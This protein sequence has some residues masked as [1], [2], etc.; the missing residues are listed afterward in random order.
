MIDTKTEPN[1]IIESQSSK[2]L[3]D[4][5]REIERLRAK[6]VK[7]EKYTYLGMLVA[8]IFHDQ[9]NVIA[10]ILTGARANLQRIAQ[11]EF[12]IKDFGIWFEDETEEFL[13][14]TQKELIPTI[15]RSLG[16]IEQK[17]LQLADLSDSIEN[18]TS[19]NPSLVS[20]NTNLNEILED[21]I[22]ITIEAFRNKTEK[23]G[24]Q[25][26][27][28]NIATQLDPLI[29]DA[30]AEPMNL[31]RIL[32][33]LLDNAF[34]AVCDKALTAD[35]SYNPT[36][37]VITQRV[38]NCIKIEIEDNGAGMVD[39][40]RAFLTTVTTKPK[41]EGS[42]LGLAIVKRLA[43]EENIKLQAHTGTYG[44]IRVHTGTYGY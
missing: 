28:I 23:A 22:K 8:E 11:I 7:Q 4:K 39:I 42:G 13:G 33:N 6:I 20:S 41:G 32:L 10:S 31:R 30:K 21:C 37:T 29:H 18:Y 38:D 27:E 16:N 17:A 24:K 44:Y 15:K 3:A 14:E 26:S 40:Y 12:A 9:K 2:I 35:K 1:F 34:Y 36:V 43:H 5:D 19:E 25:Y